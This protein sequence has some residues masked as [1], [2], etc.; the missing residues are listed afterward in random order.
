[1][2][3]TM[4]NGKYCIAITCVGS[5]VG[6]SVITS[7]NLS[8]LPIISVGLGSNP[9]G[10][11][12]YDCMEMA[13]LPS[14]YSPAYVNALI[15]KCLEYKIDL[16]IPGLDDEALLLS[17]NLPK[18]HAVGLKVVVS[19]PALLKLVRD[20]ERMT[21]VLSP[22][23]DIF[24]NSYRPANI[25][26]AINLGKAKYPLIAKPRSGFA[27]RSV[28]IILNENDLGK[29]TEAHIIQDLAI[30]SQE[31]P[32]RETYLAQLEKHIN[33]QICEISIQLV[34][35]KNGEMM[36][37][38]ASYNKLH[39]GVPIEII[40]YDS[41]YLWYEID[42]LIPALKKIGHRGPL[43]IQGRLTDDGLK[44]FE[45]NARFTGITGLRAIM[46]FNEV[47]CCI[48]EW[49]GIGTGRNILQLNYDRFGV[50]QTA[51][52][53]I[54]I[55]N[56]MEVKALSDSLNRRKLKSVKTIMVTGARG[57]LG[58]N[59]V[60][61]LAQEGYNV[62]AFNRC[63]EQIIQFFNSYENIE[64]F[65]EQ[66]LVSGV[67][68]LGLVDYLIHCGFA[69]PHCTND[70]IADSLSFTNQLIGRAISNQVPAIINISSQSVY[71]T[72]Q[73]PLWTEKMPVF[74]ETVYAQA[75]HAAELITENAHYLNK[76]TFVT[77]LRL[78]TLAGTQNGLLPM[79]LVFKFVARALNEEPLSIFG[80]QQ[81]MERLDVRDAINAIIALLKTDYHDWD[82]VYNL[83][84]GRVYSVLDIAERVAHIAKQYDKDVELEI[85]PSTE[86]LPSFGMDSLRF[87]KLTGWTPRYDM[88]DII[89]SLFRALTHG[90]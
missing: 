26:E 15:E 72:K 59:L 22:I 42:K 90:Q 8:N 43:N 39:N 89:D 49:L 35:D 48:K 58:Q 57:Y 28:E 66:D 25:K 7:C 44:L 77:S 19:E 36:G 6:Q 55:A 20:K 70:Q 10:Y 73:I 74:P 84:S 50:R 71:G 37:K 79:D 76:Q 60:K 51:D 86:C 9:F 27:S 12:A 54:S 13:Y 31:D 68:S 67:L 40:P 2:K 24:V 29:I 75:K 46:G 38:M 45:M 14:I 88:D 53:S 81:Q 78:C 63:K 47:E 80:G 21:E 4:K 41:D 33:P 18:L 23:T 56:N 3:K 5:G 32:F 65:D 69:R 61:K 82:A 87:K 34:T 11:G 1:M 85:Q 17:E 83:G 62:F 16:I 64:C 52:K 30:P